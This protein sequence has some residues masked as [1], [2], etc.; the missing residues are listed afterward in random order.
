MSDGAG[1][2]LGIGF[3]MSLV[4]IAVLSDLLIDA[5]TAMWQ[6]IS[7]SPRDSSRRSAKAKPTVS[8]H[9]PMY[10]SSCSSAVDI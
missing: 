6:V 10:A 7:N 1:L 5:V 8:G 9:I 3:S 2:Y 4:L